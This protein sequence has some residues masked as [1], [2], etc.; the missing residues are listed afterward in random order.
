MEQPAL[1]TTEERRKLDSFS[2]EELVEL[3]ELQ[4]KWV[5]LVSHENKKLREQASIPPEQTLVVG[6][7]ILLLRNRLFGKS[8]ERRVEDPPKDPKNKKKR[9]EITLLPSR[10]YPNLPLVETEIGFDKGHEPDCGL[11]GERLSDMRQ[12]EDSEIISIVPKVYH[13]KRYK[14]VKY[15]CEK[16]HGDIQT[17]PVIPRIVPGGAFADALTID[18]VVSKYAD[19]C[20][21]ERYVTQA[22]RLGVK[23]LP[24]Q[25]LIE[26][27]HR[28]SDFYLPI[29]EELKNEVQASH[30]LHAD[31]TW[32]RMMTKESKKRWQLW[33][34]FNRTSAYY[35]AHDTRAGSVAQGFLKDSH[36]K[37]VVSDAYSGYGKSVKDTGKK[38]SFCNAHSRRKFIEAEEN[39]PEATTVI[40][41]YKRIYEIE[42]E[43]KELPSNDRLRERELRAAPLMAEIKNYVFELNPLPKSALGIARRYLID[44]WEGLTAFLKDGELPI[45]NNPAE[46]GLRGPVLGR[47]NFLG[48]HS[49]RGAETTAVFYSLIESCKLNGVD[50]FKYLSDMAARKHQSQD[51][52]TPKSYAA[53]PVG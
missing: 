10:R 4:Q 50:P 27:T 31:E 36:A 16:C 17:A 5:E 2:R 34:F 15:R 28:A 8:S 37:Y 21:I 9:K 11:C 49:K 53:I 24:P 6:D 18:V 19:H 51:L 30:Y 26:Q 1:L 33:G 32:W 41:L 12:T 47:K 46:R 25:S 35:E 39:Y 43:I 20:P 13:I 52:L 29:Y 7:Q 40:I 42:S 22:E 3:V 14:R 38:N 48:N 45:D 23:G 44:H